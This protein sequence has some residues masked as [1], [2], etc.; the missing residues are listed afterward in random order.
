[1]QQSHG[2]IK[3]MNFIKSSLSLMDSFC[4]L[5]S[6]CLSRLHSPHDDAAKINFFL[7][8]AKLFFRKLIISYPKKCILRE[9]ILEKVYDLTF[10]IIEKVYFSRYSVVLTI[11]KQLL[12]LTATTAFSFTISSAILLQYLLYYKKSILLLSTSP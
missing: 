12:P 9:L 3:A 10:V 4:P 11:E 5:S 7:I 8:T 6:F 2:G 1:M